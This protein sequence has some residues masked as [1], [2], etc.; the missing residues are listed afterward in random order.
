MDYSRIIIY[1]VTMVAL[2]IFLNIGGWFLVVKVINN[3]GSR[4]KFHQFVGIRHLKGRKSSSLT[5]I[6]LLSIIGVSFSSCTLTTVLSVMGGFSDDLKT[7]IISTNAHIVIDNFGSPLD[8]IAKEGESIK[9]KFAKL[10]NWRKLLKEIEQRGDIKAATPVVQGEVMINARTN[11]NGMLLKGIDTRSHSKVSG[12]LKKL[13]KGKLRYIDYPNELFQ[14]S[15]S[16][17]ATPFSKM[18]EKAKAP[19]PDLAFI[20]APKL[21]EQR[22]L[23]AL[24]VG[25][26]MSKALRLYV[27][28]E[29]KVVS[30]LGDI[31]PT[32]PIPKSR[33]FRIGGTFFSGMYAFDEHYAYTSI[34]A[35]QK[36]LN[37]GDTISEIHIS[38]PDPDQAQIV[39]AQMRKDLDNRV[40]VR[41]WQELNSELF[42]ALKL[43]KIVMF[44]LMSIAILV[45]SFAIIATLTMLVLEKGP[46]IS[47]LMTIGASRQDVQRIFRFEGMLIGAIGTV[48][49]LL[50]G[51][52]LCMTLKH[53]GLPIPPEVWYIDKLPVDI[54]YWE[55]FWVGA[56]SL[57]ITTIATIYPTRVASGITPV[58]GLK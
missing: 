15:R 32:G 44:I 45:A 19:N 57:V 2:A 20:P 8:G 29:V 27:G 39:A 3:M 10:D 36:F 22:V 4:L 1:I 17:G 42:S 54:S 25:R 47:V 13:D 38:I 55:F 33:P 40:R 23:P 37:T 50:V 52:L 56:T 9:D 5:A 18:Q 24:I 16:Q 46:E 49:G 53:V 41:S 7:K 6:G 48:T 35:A 21:P 28:E 30:P 12:V 58:E 14:L 26:E 31:G 11:N 51:Y 34:E 43:E